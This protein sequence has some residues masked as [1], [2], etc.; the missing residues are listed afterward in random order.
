GLRSRRSFCSCGN[1]TLLAPATVGLYSE[2]G[3]ED[4]YADIAIIDA[5]L[6]EAIA[7]F[8]QARVKAVIVDASQNHGGY[9]FIRR[10]IASRFAAAPATIYDKRPADAERPYHTQL[11]LTP[12]QRPRFTGP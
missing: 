4:P 7:Q 10:R 6:D 2:D 8:A 3:Q 9:D 12:S 1:V 11:L 5:T